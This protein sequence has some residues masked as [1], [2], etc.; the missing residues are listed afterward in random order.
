MDQVHFVSFINP[1][2]FDMAFLKTAK[3]KQPDKLITFGMFQLG[4]QFP[5]CWLLYVQA[6]SI[7]PKCASNSI[8]FKFF[9]CSSMW[10]D[11]SIQ[12]QSMCIKPEGNMHRYVMCMDFEPT[13]PMNYM[14]TRSPAK[15]LEK[16][17]PCKFG[18]GPWSEWITLYSFFLKEI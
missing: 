1:N 2:M 17:D 10:W 11:V 6:T 7:N 4:S 9:Q 12:R 3:W 16:F 14:L 8:K 15:M 13:N 18:F 5:A